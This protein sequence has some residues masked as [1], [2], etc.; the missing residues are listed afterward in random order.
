MLKTAVKA[1][2]NPLF[3]ADDNVTVEVAAPAQ[4][5]GYKAG[6]K[7]KVTVTLTS[8]KE[9]LTDV[10]AEQTVTVELEA[11]AEEA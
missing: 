4:E 10:K 6:D 2:I 9:G 1:K 11:Q 3:V 5:E 7:V 8:T